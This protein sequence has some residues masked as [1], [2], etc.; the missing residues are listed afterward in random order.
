MHYQHT[1]NAD[2]QQY[3]TTPDKFMPT[4]FWVL[5]FHPEMGLI[6]RERLRV[7]TEEQDEHFVTV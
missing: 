5:V 7:I 1:D 2:R 4:G 3:K 6:A